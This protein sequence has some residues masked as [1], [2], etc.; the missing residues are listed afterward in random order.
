MF[1]HL[2]L[3]RYQQ[4]LQCLG[5]KCKTSEHIR[6]AG[7]DLELPPRTHLPQSLHTFLPGKL[8]VLCFKAVSP[9]CDFLAR[10]SHSLKPTFHPSASSLLPTPP[11]GPLGKLLLLLKSLIRNFYYYIG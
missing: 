5:V 6:Q 2:L 10:C 4:P 9:F 3:Q 11:W 7:D 8:N 1:S